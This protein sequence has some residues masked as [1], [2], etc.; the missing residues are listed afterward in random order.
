MYPRKLERQLQVLQ[1]YPSAAAITGKYAVIDDRVELMGMSWGL[2]EPADGPVLRRF[3]S[4]CRP[5]LNYAVT[6]MRMDVAKAFAYDPSLRRAQDLDF[7]LKALRGR[8]FVVDD[9]AGFAYSGW[10]VNSARSRRAA[11][12]ERMIFRSYLR[13]EPVA[14][15]RLWLMSAAKSGAVTL[16]NVVARPIV[17]RR[18]R[19]LRPSEAEAGEFARA[20]DTVLSIDSATAEAGVR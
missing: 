12:F 17:E 9:V 16:P 11:R 14:A 8:D 19:L 2:A 3:D 15:A 18:H 6:L 20:L 4:L 10:R 13:S 7:M 1:T 5:P